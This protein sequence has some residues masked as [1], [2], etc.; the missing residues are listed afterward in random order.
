MQLN[1]EPMVPSVR[2][3]VLRTFS[4]TPATVSQTAQSQVLPP[5]RTFLQRVTSVIDAVKEKLLQYS[6]KNFHQRQ[7]T[8]SNR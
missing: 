8:D 3:C 6:Q 1:S 5:E 4:P 2:M 7:V